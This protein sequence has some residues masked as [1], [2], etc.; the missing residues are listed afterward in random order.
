[1]GRWRNAAWGLAVVA[2]VI[3]SAMSTNMKT[4][5]QQNR[6]QKV[7]D[8]VRAMQKEIQLLPLN[9]T[10]VDEL[11]AKQVTWRNNWT[12]LLLL[13]EAHQQQISSHWKHMKESMLA[14]AAAKQDDV[15]VLRE[16]ER[17]LMEHL[18]QWKTVQHEINATSMKILSI[19]AEIA[20][21]QE[22][23]AALRKD[24]IA[25]GLASLQRQA[26]Q[27][28]ARRILNDEAI[29]ARDAAW[30]RRRVL[31]STAVAGGILAFGT[32]VVT[33]RARWSHHESSRRPSKL[34]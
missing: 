11:R 4:E 22:E 26:D 24:A 23:K 30:F 15:N 27:D 10:I 28:E 13:E 34:E 18:R 32:V 3:F 17:E 16:R 19:K 1:M 29:A 14:N 6:V 20:R 33:F 2:V 8:R 31:T 12:A 25:K 21:R 5:Q 7:M 9:M